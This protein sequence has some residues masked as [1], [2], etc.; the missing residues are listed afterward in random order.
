MPLSDIV[1]VT[2]TTQ[3]PGVTRA[4]FGVPLIISH[5]PTWAERVRTY[6]TID[7]V[8]TDFA[9]TTQEYLAANAIFS[10][11]PRPTSLMIGRASGKPTMVQ[12]V[13]IKTVANLALYKL[14]LFS[15]GVLWDA[16][17]TS[18][19]NATN[20]E[21][22]TGL[23][24]AITPAAWQALTAYVAGDR[25]LNDTGKLYECI[26]AG[27]S[28]GAG[29]PTGTGA[30]IVDATVTWKYVVTPNFTAAATGGGGSKIVTCTGAAAGNWFAVEG[31]NN[32]DPSALCITMEVAETTTNSL[33]GGDDATMADVLTALVNASADWYGLI[34]LFKGAIATA[35]AAA[36]ESR[37]KLYPV[38]LQDSQVATVADSVA[39]DVAKSL[40]TSAY[41]RTAP[42]FHPRPWEFADAAEIGRFF[43]ISPGGDNWR[44]KTLKGVTPVTYTPTQIVNMKAKR[45]NFYYTLAGA[46]VIGGDG[47]VSSNEYIDVIRGIDWWVARVGERLANLLIQNEKIP[48][49]DD[50]IG[51]VEA[52]VRAQNDEGIA[53]GL[54]NPGS[55]PGIPAPTVTVPKSGAVSSADRQARQLNNVNTSWTLAGALNFLQVNAQVSA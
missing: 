49:T 7:D 11:S 19:A 12:T 48:Y 28:A 42:F 39:T 38:A 4:G 15:D 44:L 9:S 45:C 3:N 29:G 30:S 23:A 17:F 33:A 47:K 36:V 1:N 6:K 54:I 5:S 14:N 55:P 24:L 31:V 37:K 10:Q 52:E 8:K 21:I 51:L 16:R 18:D 43:P 20:D 40:K 13:T 32:S 46:Q 53:A 22:A 25:V 35:T 34:T 2:V 41:A 50:G 27:T 26:I